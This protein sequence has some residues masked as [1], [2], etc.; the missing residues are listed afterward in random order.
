MA[1]LEQVYYI[2]KQ[3]KFYKFNIEFLALW[4]HNSQ[5]LHTF[6]TTLFKKKVGRNSKYDVKEYSPK[7]N[8]KFVEIYIC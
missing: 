8:V 5:A 7:L 2:L 1:K 6:D 4:L 3:F